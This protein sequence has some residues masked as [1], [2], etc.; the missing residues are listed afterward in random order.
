MEKVSGKKR[1]S[2]GSTD[3]NTNNAFKIEEKRYKLYK[4]KDTD[5]S[6][7]LDFDNYEKFSQIKL[8]RPTSNEF[9]ENK[10]IIPFHIFQIEGIDGFYFIRQ[11][12][13]IEDQRKLINKCLCEWA[14]PPNVSNLDSLYGP[15][16]NLF[17]KYQQEEITKPETNEQ[18]GISLS[19]SVLLQKLRWIT[20]GNS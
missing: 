11:A 2:E 4:S 17:Q 15:Q 19:A 8:L 7:V 10:D 14:Q 3:I 9:K 20:L 1:K 13:S 12:I 6:E 5:F 16:S 18:D